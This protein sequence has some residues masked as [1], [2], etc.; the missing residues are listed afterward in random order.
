MVRLREKATPLA[1]L[2][3]GCAAFGLLEFLRRGEEVAESAPVEMPPVAVVVM[4]GFAA[5]GALAW[6]PAGVILA[7]RG[8][9]APKGAETKA[10]LFEVAGSA[11]VYLMGIAT[12][13]AALGREPSMPVRIGAVLAA[14]CAAVGYAWLRLKRFPAAFGE[15]FRNLLLGA[16][17][18]LLI[19]PFLTA[20]NVVNGFAMRA[21]ELEPE[22]HP[23]LRELLTGPSVLAMAVIF[24]LGALVAPFVEEVIFRGIVYG[25]LRKK[26]APVAAAALSGAVFAA[27]H[28]QPTQFL[29]LF[30]LG[31]ALAL[32]YEHTGSLATSVGLH[33]AN[34]AVTFAALLVAR[35]FDSGGG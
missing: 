2:G 8:V 16:A 24:I 11:G 12:L 4:L 20:T 30:L 7:W 35:L 34:N 18:Y 6:V 13:S 10:G 31:A 1:L 23:T 9:G 25:A 3:C 17:A 33:A 5:L 29:P 15:P 21:L 27:V 22:V 28:V 14:Q 26:L 19:L 32:V